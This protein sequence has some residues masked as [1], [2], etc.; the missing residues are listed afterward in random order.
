MKSI[1]KISLLVLLFSANIF[2]A[3]EQPKTNKEKESMVVISEDDLTSLIKIVK[4]H[5][6]QKAIIALNNRY[7]KE[8]PL[9]EST[10]KSTLELDYLKTEIALLEKKLAD[11]N[12]SETSRKF[13]D[14]RLVSKEIKNLED[15]INQFKSII[16]K[17]DKESLVVTLPNTQ[18]SQSKESDSHKNNQF[19]KQKLDSL[20]KVLN[21]IKETDNPNYQ[22]DFDALLERVNE[23]KN[24]IPAKNTAPS[25]YDNLVS[26]YKNFNKTIYFASNSIR[27][28]AEASQVV[29]ELVSLLSDTKLDIIIKGFASN[30]GSALYNNNLSM[31]RAE[32]VK[33]ALMIRGVHPT[34]VFTQY[35]GID[36]HAENTTKAR[37]VEVSILVRK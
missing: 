27:L 21:N 26:K 11:L 14:K 19:I 35:H 4:K 24:N 36:Y 30:K 34:R 37:R 25:T 17:L 20:Y 18:M 16:Q 9:S 28:N 10:K 31:Q 22:K 13:S 8:I 29:E 7:S 5:K 15:E 3:Q 2:S 33:K 32:E 6:K 23:L 1:K 12:N